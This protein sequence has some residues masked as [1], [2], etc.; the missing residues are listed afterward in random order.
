MSFF[1]YRQPLTHWIHVTNKT[2]NLT[3][4]TICR[5]AFFF[6][7]WAVSALPVLKILQKWQKPFTPCLQTYLHKLDLKAFL[8]F[9]GFLPFPRPHLT[10]PKNNPGVPDIPWCC[11]LFFS[12]PAS[13]CLWF[14]HPILTDHHN[15]KIIQIILAVPLVSLSL[16]WS[17]L[18]CFILL[19]VSCS[20]FGL[21]I[22]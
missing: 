22:F 10:P 14:N 8:D 2:Q 9:P 21:G 3:K 16:L 5:S 15:I 6:L 19:L 20:L 12:D 17:L 7:V 18:A 11:R 1:G 4:K 13:S